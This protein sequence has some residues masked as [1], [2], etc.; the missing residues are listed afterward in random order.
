MSEEIT[1][2]V[3][4][5]VYKNYR[6]YKDKELIIKEKENCFQVAI[7]EDSS[8]LILGKGIIK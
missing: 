2:Q 5:Y 3:T 6:T 7:H 4:K 1:Q 8:P